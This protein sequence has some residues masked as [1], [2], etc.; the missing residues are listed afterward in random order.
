MRVKL[1][2]GER[3]RTYCPQRACPDPLLV[4]D[5]AGRVV[6]EELGPVVDVDDAGL[7][8]EVLE[9]PPPVIPH[10]ASSTSSCTGTVCPT[11]CPEYPMTTLPYVVLVYPDWGLL[12][13][14]VE[15]VWLTP[16][17]FVHCLSISA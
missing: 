6:V 17:T 9:L 12:D 16:R 10:Q 5:E 4:E 8:D 14:V 13:K 7:V 15:G 3:E 11:P 1:T 2:A